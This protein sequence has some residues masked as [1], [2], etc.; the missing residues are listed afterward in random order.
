MPAVR[1]LASFALLVM[2]ATSRTHAG[3]PL[4]TDDA[5][6][7]A[8]G[9]CQVEAWVQSPHDGREYWA[10][11]ACNFTGNLELAIGAARAV[12]DDGER[13]AT[14]QL[15]AKSVLFASA[16][17]AWSF[18]VVGG[19]AR[20][21]GAPHGR[22]AFQTYFGKALASWYPRDDVEMDFDLGAANG[23]GTGVFALASAAIQYAVVSNVQL[24]A[25]AFRDEPGRAKYQVGVRWTVVPDRLDAYVSYGNRFGNASSQWTIVGIRLQS[26]RLLP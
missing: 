1:P 16:D 19:A 11:P 21:T 9:T 18:G 12:A 3:Q 7:V 26:P 17:K 22:S 10:Q 2:L 25:E 15:Q 4:A 8:A 14:V 6:V 20:D 5:A 13:S 23:Y 24:M